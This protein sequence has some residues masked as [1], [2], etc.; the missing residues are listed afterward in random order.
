LKMVSWFPGVIAFGISLPLYEI[1]QLSFLSM[2]L[3]AAEGLDFI[4]FFIV[5]KVRWWL[6][7]V[8]SMFF[9]FN[10]WGKKRGMENGVN[11]PLVGK[12]EFVCHQ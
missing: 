7:E 6:G 12:S 4:L 8:F 9:C 11:S 1:F 10:I 2:T 5:D 3:V